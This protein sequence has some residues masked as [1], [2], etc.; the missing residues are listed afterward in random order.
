MVEV[1]V[2]TCVV[3]PATC[4]AFGGVTQTLRAL[5]D[6][7]GVGKDPG[8]GLFFLP[9]VFLS[10]FRVETIFPASE[11][12]LVYPRHFLPHPFEPVIKVLRVEV[13]RFHMKLQFF[14]CLCALANIFGQDLAQ[15]FCSMLR[16]RYFIRR[17]QYGLDRKK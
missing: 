12:G 4:H 1:A 10:A 9:F 2:L 16:H 7:L 5:F 13:R 8:C 15:I 11:H 6:F 14:I 17:I 3:L